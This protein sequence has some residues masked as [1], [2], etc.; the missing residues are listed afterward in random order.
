MVKAEQ[1]WSAGVAARQERAEAPGVC[2]ATGCQKHSVGGE[3]QRRGP[4]VEAI[5]DHLNRGGRRSRYRLRQQTAGPSSD[6]SN[7]PEASDSS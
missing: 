6:R 3:D 4:H 1:A 7:R 2:R 5:R